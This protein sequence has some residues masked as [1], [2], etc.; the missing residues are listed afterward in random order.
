MTVGCV[1]FVHENSA[2]DGPPNPGVNADTDRETVECPDETSHVRITRASTG[3]EFLF[4][5]YGDR[6]NDRRVS[7]R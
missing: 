3:N 2:P 4:E 5:C 7:R 6:D 1:G